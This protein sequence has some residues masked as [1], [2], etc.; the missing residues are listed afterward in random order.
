MDEKANAH[1]HASNSNSP[2]ALYNA[3]PPTAVR[4]AS[5]NFPKLLAKSFERSKNIFEEVISLS[6]VAVEWLALGLSVDWAAYENRKAT[7]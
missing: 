7:K 5:P 2:D 3:P 6:V 1:D 4:G